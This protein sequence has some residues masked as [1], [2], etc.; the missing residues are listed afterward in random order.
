MIGEDNMNPEFQGTSQEAAK[1]HEI[2]S[3]RQIL[4]KTISKILRSR[5]TQLAIAAAIGL[6]LGVAAN[7]HFKDGVPNTPQGIVQDIKSLPS[8]WQKLVNPRESFGG[9]QSGGA[10]ASGTWTE[11]KPQKK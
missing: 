4:A 2:L 9:G 8:S 3:K 1:P 7:S 5:I 11:I 6:N 10:G